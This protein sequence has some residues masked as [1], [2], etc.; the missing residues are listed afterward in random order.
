MAKRIVRSFLALPFLALAACDLVAPKPSVPPPPSKPSELSQ[1]SNESKRLRAFYHAREARLK[2]Q[3]LLREDFAPGDAAFT[4]QDLVRNFRRVALYTE[5]PRNLPGLVAR[6]TVSQLGRWH[7]TVS[8]GIHFGK[9]V[10]ASQ[11]RTDEAEMKSFLRRLSKLTGL[12]VRFTDVKNA[13]FLIMVM[14]KDALRSEAAAVLSDV[15]Y[16]DDRMVLEIQTLPSEI[17][18][19]VYGQTAAQPPF[20]YVGSVVVIRSELGPLTRK[21]CVH[22]EIAQGLGLVNDA[23]DARPSIFNDDEEFALLTRHDEMLLKML[24]DPRLSDGMTPQTQAPILLQVATDA[25]KQTR[26]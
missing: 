26:I 6:E 21:S 24:Y 16:A 25:M 23:P 20:G 2:A 11:R 8:V 4:P 9:L 17:D 3:G 10:P 5:Y 14:S 18:C 15:P 7:K 13:N 12:K 1:P 19:V 22:E